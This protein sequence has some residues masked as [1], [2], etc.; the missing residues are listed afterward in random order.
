[1]TTSSNSPH[2]LPPLH[3][4]SEAISIASS[5]VCYRTF[6]K[7]ISYSLSNYFLIFLF[8]STGINA[9]Y[10]SVLSFL[11]MGPCS[12][13]LCLWQTWLIDC[14]VLPHWAEEDIQ[15]AF[16]H[17]AINNQGWHAQWSLIAHQTQHG[18]R[19]WVASPNSF[20]DWISEMNKYHSLSFWK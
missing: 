3:P 2:P 5:S 15:N 20:V 10:I 11:H 4:P 7:P 13:L 9:S 12:L 18:A 19:G 14:N 1:M 17:N 16:Q 8:Y 6:Y